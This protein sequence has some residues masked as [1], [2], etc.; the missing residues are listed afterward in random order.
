M[1]DRFYSE[2]EML[3]R[4]V[5]AKAS[6]VA[7]HDPALV[8]RDACGALI[9]YGH[10]GITTSNMGWEIDHIKPVSRG[11]RTE[12]SNL[13]PLHWRNNRSKGDSMAWA[14]AMRAA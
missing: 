10:Y 7:F 3:K 13:Q 12:L 11:G 4:M 1:F 9:A 14:C 8:R 5:W 6:P 2:Y